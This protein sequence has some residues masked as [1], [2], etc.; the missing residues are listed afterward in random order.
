MKVSF[1]VAMMCL[2]NFGCADKKRGE[3]KQTSHPNI[4][5]GT[6]LPS[7]SKGIELEA[8]SGKDDYYGMSGSWLIVTNVDRKKITIV[9]VEIN[10]SNKQSSST[11][12]EG[13]GNLPLEIL[14]GRRISFLNNIGSESVVVWAKVETSIGTFLLER[15]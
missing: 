12:V 2:A 10:G 6:S 7:I 15:K 8:R 1:L 5:K 3:E 4:P 13:K 11:F 14:P 9:K